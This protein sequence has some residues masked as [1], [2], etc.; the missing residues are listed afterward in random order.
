VV[1]PAPR[2]HQKICHRLVQ[3]LQPQETDAPDIVAGAAWVVRDGELVRIPDVMVLA[4]APAW[5]LVGDTALVVVDV[6]DAGHEDLARKAGQY[7]TVGVRQ[8]WALAS[9]RAAAP[10]CQRSGSPPPRRTET[11]TAVNGPLRAPHR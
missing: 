6:L 1:N 9:G 3:Q 5:D 4:D 2:G 10:A 8:Y 7:L 11:A